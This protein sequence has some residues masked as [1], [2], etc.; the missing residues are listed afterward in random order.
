[1][2]GC[3]RI[4]NSWGKSKSRDFGVVV[5]AF[6]SYP[7]LVSDFLYSDDIP[8]RPV[9]LKAPV[10]DVVPS[11]ADEPG[12]LYADIL[13]LETHLASV[14][15]DCV[16]LREL[17]QTAIDQVADRNRQIAALKRRVA[18]QQDQIRRLFGSADD[19]RRQRWDGPIT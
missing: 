14:Q 18:D 10:F 8:W 12:M 2:G 17:V 19:Q 1:M 11:T 9:K 3:G 13:A 16:V 5:F 4:G 15:A 7:K 6:N